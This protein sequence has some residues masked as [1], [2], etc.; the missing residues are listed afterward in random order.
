MRKPIPRWV[1]EQ[2]RETAAIGGDPDLMVWWEWPF[3]LLPLGGGYRSIED[4]GHKSFTEVD[5]E[6]A[7]IMEQRKRKKRE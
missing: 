7:E 1:L 4:Y 3:P 5:P 6:I 2:A